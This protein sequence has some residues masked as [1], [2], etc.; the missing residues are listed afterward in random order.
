MEKQATLQQHW[1]SLGR[2]HDEKLSYTAPGLASRSFGVY[3]FRFED[4]VGFGALRLRLKV[5]EMM[6]MAVSTTMIMLRGDEEDDDGDG[7]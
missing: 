5:C 2:K 7:V 6:A 1:R 4:C 3:G